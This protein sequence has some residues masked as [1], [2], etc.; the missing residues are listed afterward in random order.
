[1]SNFFFTHKAFKAFIKLAQH[2]M[3]NF[4]C[5]VVDG[6]TSHTIGV[7]LK[8]RQFEEMGCD[9]S[10]YLYFNI[11]IIYILYKTLP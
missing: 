6:V 10:M 8:D 11:V 9:T 2:F 7:P 1:M 4:I 5:R 3:F